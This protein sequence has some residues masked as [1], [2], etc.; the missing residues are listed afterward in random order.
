MGLDD[1]RR[2]SCDNRK[3][4]SGY[5]CLLYVSSHWLHFHYRAMYI[6]PFT[7]CRWSNL[8]DIAAF[9]FIYSMWRIYRWMGIAAYIRLNRSIDG[10]S[11]MTISLKFI[12]VVAISSFRQL[13]LSAIGLALSVAAHLMTLAGL[14]VQ[15]WVSF[16]VPLRGMLRQGIV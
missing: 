6:T 14:D 7:G 9:R 13:N 10:A 1:F 5:R 15:R 2:F 3:S 8:F 11:P 16:P 12:T 4:L